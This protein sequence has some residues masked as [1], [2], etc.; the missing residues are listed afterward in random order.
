MVINALTTITDDRTSSAINGNRPLQSLFIKA[1]NSQAVT[2]STINT[3]S[4]KEE[5][6]RILGS[7]HSLRTT[8]YLHFSIQF[9]YYFTKYCI[10]F[11]FY[12]RLESVI[13]RI[14][15][16]IGDHSTTSINERSTADFFLGFRF[17]L[18]HQFSL[19]FFLLFFA[20]FYRKFLSLVG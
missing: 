6:H 15:H 9:S 1:H 20:R 13:K 7:L 17:F 5:R 19:S 10:S 8:I 18:R 3:S 16:L 14:S 4:T 2:T 12:V 11:S